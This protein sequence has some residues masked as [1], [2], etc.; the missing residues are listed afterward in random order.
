MLA[1]KRGSP[2]GG[3]RCE[4]MP[5]PA[6]QLNLFEDD[7][8]QQQVNSF[9]AREGWKGTANPI[10]LVPLLSGPS[11]EGL[12]TQFDDPPPPP[13][14]P[15]PAHPNPELLCDSTTTTTTLEIF[16]PRVE[17]CDDFFQL[18][19]GP[20]S[21]EKEPVLLVPSRGKEYERAERFA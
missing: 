4:F 16:R 9:H 6:I 19:R 17:E 5:E 18:P 7:R 12:L 14:L 20:L 2:E 8:K 3:D 11:R 10:K 15:H 13:H 1:L 21:F